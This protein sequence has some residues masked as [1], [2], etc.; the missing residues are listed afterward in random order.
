MKNSF[1]DPVDYIYEFSKGNLQGRRN[2]PQRMINRYGKNEEVI[3]RRSGP[4]FEYQVGILWPHIIE[5]DE[6]DDEDK[7]NKKETL[8]EE[9]KEEDIIVN[10][11]VKDRIEKKGFS[12]N[13]EDSIDSDEENLIS[14]AYRK[15][16]RAMGIS[17]RPC[18]NADFDID[19]FAAQ[20]I[21]DDI[22][23]ELRE[24]SEFKS[25]NIKKGWYRK[26]I[27]EKKFRIKNNQLP[28]NIGDQ[29]R[30]N[31]LGDESDPE[32]VFTIR[33]LSN[34]VYTAYLFNE[35][36]GIPRSDVAANC[37]YQVEFFLSSTT[38]FKSYS[39]D[40]PLN[41]SK[42]KVHNFDL[43]YSDYP[44]YA[45]G[46]GC[47]PEWDEGSKVKQ[48]RAIHIPKTEV[49]PVKAKPLI[50]D[51]KEVK[52]NMEFLSDLTKKEEIVALLEKFIS[53]YSSWIKEKM[54]ESLNLEDSFKARATENLNDC[55]LA[56]N[57]MQKGISALKKKENIFK[58]FCLMNRAMLLQQIR[59]NSEPWILTDD[60]LDRKAPIVEDKTSWPDW[61]KDKQINTK[62]GNWRPFQ[63]AF[64]LM[65][66]T[67]LCA[68]LNQDKAQEDRS[69]V[70][71]IWFPTGGGKT[72]AYFGLTAFNIF[73]R[74]LLNK[75]D[76]ATS[77]ITRYTYR[78][79]TAQ[80]F[81]RSAAL[82]ASCNI[83]REEN[84]EELG[85]KEINLGLWIGKTASHN[86]IKS[87]IDECREI[88]ATKLKNPSQPY[89]K[90][91]RFVLQSCPNCKVSFFQNTAKKI[92]NLGIKVVR[93]N[94]PTRVEY[95][96]PNRLCEFSS[97][98]IPVSSID[99]ELFN[100]PPTFLIG[101]V[102]KFALLPYRR[103]ARKFFGL[104]TQFSPP[105]L[106]IQDE[107]HLISG[108]LGSV[109]GIY[110]RL[111][112][113]LIVNA[114]NSKGFA[115]KIVCSTATINSANDQIK[116][117]YGVND[118]S[119]IN[120]FP[121]NAIK[122][123]DNFFSEVDLDSKGR[124]YMGLMP[125]INSD[126][127]TAKRYYLSALL[128]AGKNLQLNLKSKLYDY[129]AYWTVID[130]YSSLRDLGVG[131]ST[132]TSDVA[133]QL[134]GGFKKNYNLKPNEIRKLHNIVELTGR[135]PSQSI[136][137]RLQELSLAHQKGGSNTIDICLTTN[138]FSVGV[139]ISR[140]G[141]MFMNNHTKT[142][143]EYIQATS[144]VGRSSNGPGMVAVQYAPSRARDR[145]Y[146]EQFQSFHSRF[147]SHVEP[148]SVTPFSYRVID[149]VLP[150]IIIGYIRLIKN[151]ENDKIDSILEED[152]KD[153]IKFVD[154]FSSLCSNKNEEKYIID[155]CNQI[156][157]LI[158][159]NKGNYSRF[160]SMYMD[161][162]FE[163]LIYPENIDL[164]A[165]GFKN[166]FHAPTSMRSVDLESKAQLFWTFYQKAVNEL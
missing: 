45:I 130:Y 104:D 42:G 135:D 21:E 109:Y 43:L 71:L 134:E 105:D 126:A 94:G 91:H 25:P 163:D 28:K 143:S 148:T 108:P 154:K 82:I 142:T 23:E 93:K 72:E 95:H 119:N 5:E 2:I 37:F 132:A 160:F 84:I 151:Y 101:T 124:T 121:S 79:L 100:N 89:K 11:K 22:I 122:I 161:L 131:Y 149:K 118:N 144:R 87:S 20:Y 112:N 47:S 103:Q 111:I 19:V 164:D 146:F 39:K 67:S 34:S 81:E 16:Q 115:P 63:L 54:K 35:K 85:E 102:D 138:M 162:G 57:R 38:G 8:D 120:I 166:S 98:K 107:L 77:I 14:L 99:E 165:H 13:E 97:R 52:L 83:V 44:T 24:R 62:L 156:I 123:W 58:S 158:K 128:Q 147:Y 114:A 127:V 76:D 153:C 65:N 116:N 55:E 78:V 68:E 88:T 129:D 27:G 139:D 6:K 33:K 41:K 70:D 133:H 74:R 31:I 125:R 96:C 12:N 64:V 1:K 136:P 86:K 106:I 141:L 75:E 90:S 46:H 113:E 10:Q 17:F 159:A 30:K 140:L 26:S 56:C 36:K 157:D 53:T 73:S 60:N 40:N 117:L 150:A 155:K 137:E 9:D 15:D 69:I 51:D 49:K 4:I 66:L 152:F 92:N 7:F 32:L 61:D 59:H 3:I 145:S 48:I 80:Q 110:E 29:F 18:E 50:I